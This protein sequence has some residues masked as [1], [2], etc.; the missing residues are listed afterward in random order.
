[1]LLR[2]TPIDAHTGN[3]VGCGPDGVGERHRGMEEHVEA[4]I[5]IP[6]ADVADTEASTAGSSNRVLSSS[7]STTGVGPLR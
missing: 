7:T 2:E 1:M 5:V 3:S 4:G 6:D